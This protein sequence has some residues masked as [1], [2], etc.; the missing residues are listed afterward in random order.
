[1]ETSDRIASARPL[2]KST[3]IA[4]GGQALRARVPRDFRTLRRITTAISI[5]LGPLAVGVVRATVPAVNPSDGKAAITTMMANP[6]MARIELTAGI[7]ATLFLPFAIVG[8]TRLVMRGA[9]VLAML[10]GGLALIGW[11]LVPTLVTIDAMTYVMAHSGANPT[12]FASL[13]DQVNGNIVVN[14]LTTIFVVG[15]E[16]GT[17]LPG[18]GLVRARVVPLWAAVAVMLGI[19]LHPVGH[20]LGIRPLD[21]LGFAL[22][23]I[24]CIAAA[25]AILIIPND[26]WDLPSLAVYNAT[27]VISA[28]QDNKV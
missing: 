27:R 20:A 15:H 23:A 13:W 1:M 16:L 7:V 25:R 24:G 8:L 5:V 3:E 2:D 9:P 28:Q 10:G 21:I 11:A 12:Q 4:A 14:L 22:L 26:A 6:D 19:L 18:I 17:L